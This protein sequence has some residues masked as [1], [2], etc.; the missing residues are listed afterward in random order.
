MTYHIKNGN[1]NI[2]NVYIYPT[3]PGEVTGYG[4]IIIHINEILST[5]DKNTN[6]NPNHN[7]HIYLENKYISI[8]FENSDCKHKFLNT[9]KHGLRLNTINQ[10]MYEK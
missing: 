10:I 9:I 7:M 2:N 4:D 1:Y 6:G 8:Y 5:E 3:E